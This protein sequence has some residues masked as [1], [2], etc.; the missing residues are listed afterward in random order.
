[1]THT[2][3]YDIFKQKTDPIEGIEA[4]MNQCTYADMFTWVSAI[5]SN[6][7]RINGGKENTIHFGC[8]VG[9]SL[10]NTHQAHIT[11]AIN[12]VIIIRLIDVPYSRYMTYVRI[13]NNVMITTYESDEKFPSSKFIESKIVFVPITDYMRWP[14][15]LICKHIAIYLINGNVTQ[16]ATVLDDECTTQTIII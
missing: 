16:E 4:V 11:I 6:H 8:S 13:G 2:E 14:A 7:I 3:A 5:F 15:E 9:T 12:N 10:H 1:M